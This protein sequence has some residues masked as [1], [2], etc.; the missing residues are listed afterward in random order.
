MCT[1]KIKV[2]VVLF[3]MFQI[4]VETDG[5]VPGLN[6][7]LGLQYGLSK[8]RIIS[9]YSNSRVPGGLI[10]FLQYWTVHVRYQAC[11]MCL[12]IPDNVQE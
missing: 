4:Q 11:P 7:H 2:K 1:V 9:C 12:S 8:I 6:P 5:K 3:A 10:S